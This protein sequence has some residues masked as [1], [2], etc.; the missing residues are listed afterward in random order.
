MAGSVFYGGKWVRNEESLNGTRSW[1]ASWLNQLWQQ[2]ALGL[3]GTFSVAWWFSVRILIDQGEDG[4]D[5]GICFGQ[6]I[7]F[8]HISIVQVWVRGSLRLQ[9]AGLRLPGWPGFPA[10]CHLLNNMGTLEKRALHLVTLPGIRMNSRMNQLEVYFLGLYIRMVH[11]CLNII[12][13]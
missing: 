10:L 5:G 8:H 7:I 6:W 11:C 1:I 13:P 2:L 3:C 4:R 12:R 9:S